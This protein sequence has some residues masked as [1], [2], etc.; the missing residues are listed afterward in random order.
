MLPL[1]LPRR[2]T[3]QTAAFC[4]LILSTANLFFTYYNVQVGEGG[5]DGDDALDT[6][7]GG[8]SGEVLDDGLGEL[9]VG[10]CNLDPG[11]KA[12]GFKFSY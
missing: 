11:L 7:D 8:R 1:R 10:R 12:T 3:P 9:G 5:V 2:V 4:L 6:N